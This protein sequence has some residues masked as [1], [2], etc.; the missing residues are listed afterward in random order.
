MAASCKLLSFA[1]VIVAVSP[2]SLAL[3]YPWLRSRWVWLTEGTPLRPSFS[4][5]ERGICLELLEWR[6][7]IVSGGWC[8]RSDGFFP[9]CQ[10]PFGQLPTSSIPTLSIPISSMLTKWELTKWELTK[11]EVEEVGRFTIL[12]TSSHC[13]RSGKFIAYLLSRDD[14]TV[15]CPWVWW[16][17]CQF[18]FIPKS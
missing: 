11:W 17:S 14:K 3:C 15:W 13:Y 2:C 18:V 8:G 4:E 12:H 10:F 6:L 7:I 1:S 9:L 5:Q 16:N